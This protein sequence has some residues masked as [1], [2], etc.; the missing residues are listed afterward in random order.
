MQKGGL[1]SVANLELAT[2]SGLMLFALGIGPIYSR[3]I[4]GIPLH[5]EVIKYQYF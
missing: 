1:M 5:S 3:L 2:I 4:L